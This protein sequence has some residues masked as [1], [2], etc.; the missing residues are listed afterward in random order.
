M[1]FTLVDGTREYRTVIGLT[2]CRVTNPISPS[3]DIAVDYS[4]MGLLDLLIGHGADVNAKTKK[5]G[6]T[7]LHIACSI[8]HNSAQESVSFDAVYKLLEHGATL[9]APVRSCVFPFDHH[10]AG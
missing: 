4:S 8:S 1:I 3:S 9:D 5:E 2:V 6:F 7:P 10:S